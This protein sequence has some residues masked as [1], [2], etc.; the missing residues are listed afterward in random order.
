MDRDAD[1]HIRFCPLQSS[2]G[3]RLC[4]EYGA[5]TDV[6]TAVLIEV[7][8]V[9]TESDAI[10]R[11]FPWMGLPWIWLGRFAL[12]VPRVIRDV[13]YRAFARHRGTIWKG[14]KRWMGW[15]D[16]CL[17]AYRERILGLDDMPT[18]LP[19]DWG[20]GEACLGHKR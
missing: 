2:L 10:L 8:Q 11:M 6:S 20:F 5:P 18:P 15:G 16:V 14:V 3:Q 1:D 13:C 4:T 19:K 9:Y 12:C 17:E 7:G